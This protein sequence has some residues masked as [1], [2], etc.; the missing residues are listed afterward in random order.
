MGSLQGKTVESRPWSPSNDP[1]DGDGQSQQAQPL[2]Q[3]L[4]QVKDSSWTPDHGAHSRPHAPQYKYNLANLEDQGDSASLFDGLISPSDWSE[5]IGD[6]SGDGSVGAPQVV[7]PEQVFEEAS[8][9]HALV[10]PA[11]G[12]INEDKHKQGQAGYRSI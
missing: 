2:G 3:H 5:P 4:Q 12:K 7:H 10:Q 11:Q 6:G 9:S 8:Q 1:Q